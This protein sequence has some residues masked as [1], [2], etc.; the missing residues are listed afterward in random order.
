M[1]RRPPTAITLSNEDIA[2]FEEA[3]KLKQLQKRLEA[4]AENSQEGHKNPEA[5]DGAEKPRNR[6][7]TDRIMGTGGNGR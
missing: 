4:T 3:R 2:K 7:A 5:Q 6:N 1:L